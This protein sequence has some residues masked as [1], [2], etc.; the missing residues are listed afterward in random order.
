MQ[1]HAES[2]V[3]I[4]RHRERRRLLEHH[5]DA[6]AHDGGV[7]VLAQ[8]VG[9]VEQDL[10]FRALAR[11]ELV[12]AVEDAQQRDLPQPEGPIIA[13]TRFSGISKLMFFSA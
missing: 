9:A 11:I 8:Q 1:L 12:H 6:R 13:V 10:P 2:D 5:A 7:E 3:V 4:D